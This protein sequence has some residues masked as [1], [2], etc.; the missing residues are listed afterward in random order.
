MFNA[1]C[2]NQ[3]NVHFTATS[4]DCT[5]GNKSGVWA[6]AGVTFDPATNRLYVGTG[7]GT[8]NSDQYRRVPGGGDS[9]CSRSTRTTHGDK[10][11][12]LPSTKLRRATTQLP[13]RTATIWTWAARQHAHSPQQRK[14]NIQPPG[15]AERGK[16]REAAAHQSRQ[17]ERARGPGDTWPVRVYSTAL[18]TAGEAFQN[19]CATWINPADGSRRGSS[20]SAPATE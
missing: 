18:P 8:F 2:S 19:P 15:C 17:P 4:P 10:D 9:S 13:C 7:N 6:K 5:A 1:M 3:A 20:S 14:R 16:G 11:A 12:G